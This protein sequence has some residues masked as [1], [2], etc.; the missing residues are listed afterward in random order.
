MGGNGQTRILLVDSDTRV[1]FALRTLLQ[2]EQGQILIEESEDVVALVAHV[3]KF[4]PH[5]VFL[6][7]EFPG[8]P[9]AA[10]LLAL[11][12]LD[13]HPGVVVLS[14][15][16]E[17]KEAALA[18]GADAFVCKGD[19]PEYLLNSFRALASR[20]EGAGQSAISPIKL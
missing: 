3:E 20:S 13:D 15:R 19:P 4:K 16:P 6:D 10:L 11:N 17:S 5:L 7:W 18:A 1:R 14:T 9:A 2:Q 8:R 12:G